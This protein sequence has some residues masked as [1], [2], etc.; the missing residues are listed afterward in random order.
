MFCNLFISKY[1][2]HLQTAHMCITVKRTK[3]EIQAADKRTFGYKIDSFTFCKGSW[4]H[5]L[6]HMCKQE[7]HIITQHPFQLLKSHTQKC[8][9]HAT[10]RAALCYSRRDLKRDDT[11]DEDFLKEQSFSTDDPCGQTGCV[12]S[13]FKSL[14]GLV[15]AEEDGHP[16]EGSH[17]CAC[18]HARQ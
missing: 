15:S 8:T 12:Q 14:T 1:K 9:H 4:V 10:R 17:G 2:L 5:S 13:V 11:D 16:E 3:C 7:Q 18:C 6:C